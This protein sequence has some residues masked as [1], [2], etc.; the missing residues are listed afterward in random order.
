MMPTE[1]A[2]VAV[3]DSPAEAD[4]TLRELREA[5]FETRS[6]S[7]AARDGARQKMV[8]CYYQAGTGMRCCGHAGT[9]WNGVWEMLPGWAILDIPDLGGLLVAGRLAE[10][11]V[12]GLENAAI[13]SGLS[14]LGAAL[15]SIGIPKEAIAE[16]EAAL[17]E[18]KYL[19]IAHGPAGE[20]AR[21][22]RVFRAQELG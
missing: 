9:F 6:V 19:V 8:A 16:Y 20:V 22:K 15:Y 1:N 17:A 18:E 7:V 21:A 11:V 14:A 13:F 2:T 3:C 4:R 10:W 12:A 5:G